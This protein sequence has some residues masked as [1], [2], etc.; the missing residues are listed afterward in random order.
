MQLSDILEFLRSHNVGYEFVGD[1]SLNIDQIASLD[2]AQPGQASFLT[3]HKYKSALETTT[4][5]LVVLKPGTEC[6]NVPAVIYHS[7]P[8]YVYALIA[9]CLNPLPASS[10]HNHASVSIADSADID[11]TVELGENVVIKAGVKIQ[12]RTVIQANTVVEE[13]VTIGHDCLI[14]P[15]VTIRHDCVLGNQ[16]IIEAGSVIGG[17]GFGWANHEGNWI[18]IPQIGRVVIG[19]HVSIGNNVAIDRGAINDTIIADNCIIDN[20]VHIA[21]NVE[22]GS[23]SAIAGQV[24]FAGSTKIGRYCTVGGQAGFAGHIDIAD[25]SHFMAKAGVTHS[26]AKSGTYSGFPAHDVSDWQKSTVRVRQ[27]DKMAKQ[28]KEL[29]KAIKQ[30]TQS[31]T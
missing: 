19:N 27:L 13:N 25:K 23:G 1:S 24:G 3:D 30:L 11:S 18:K 29:Q 7:N 4:A 26:I 9:Q 8:Y 2:S 17:D 16:V 20:L 31:E 22:I 14:G 21:H 28:I 15:N 10:G 5:S 6:L 12:S